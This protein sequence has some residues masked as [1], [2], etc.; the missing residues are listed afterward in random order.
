MVGGGGYI[1]SFLR[2]LGWELGKR[3][4]GKGWE[5][6]WVGCGGGDWGWVFV[7]RDV[8]FMESIVEGIGGLLCY[9]FHFRGLWGFGGKGFKSGGIGLGC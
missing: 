6:L 1:E 9:L 2:G 3:G 7:L 4:R 8:A 5:G